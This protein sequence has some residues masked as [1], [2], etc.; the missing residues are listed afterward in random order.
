MEGPVLFINACVREASR[1]K[2]LADRLLARLRG[3]V[4]EVRVGALAFPRADEA[5][6]RRRDRLL[7]E[8]DLSDPLFEPALRFSRAETV[9]IAAPYW[10][11]SFPAALRQYLEQV[12][13]S[14]ITFRYTEEGFPVGLCRAKWLFYVTTAG[15]SYVPEEF[16]FGYVR[17]LAQSFYGI[18]DVRLIKA[19]G[20][21]L[22][23]ADEEAILRAAEAEVDR[24]DL[25]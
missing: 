8:G 13:V 1:T 7:A 17:A 23:G 12:N 19:V 10:D 3:P 11:L 6:L 24:L 9:V 16:G 15:G 18:P 5:F 21:D 20:L 4:E 14:G 2:R 25:D 22:D